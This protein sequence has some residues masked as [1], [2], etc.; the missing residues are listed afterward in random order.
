[1]KQETKSAATTGAN[2][3]Y[4]SVSSVRPASD[5]TARVITGIPGVSVPLEASLINWQH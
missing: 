1:M 4:T 2:Y 5:Y 3:Y